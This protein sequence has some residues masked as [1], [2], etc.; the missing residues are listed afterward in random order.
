MAPKLK[1]YFKTY[2]RQKQLQS[3]QRNC[4]KEIVKEQ[5]MGAQAYNPSP[6]RL[7]QDSEF[8]GPE[9]KSQILSQKKKK[10]SNRSNNSSVAASAGC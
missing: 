7:G 5:H 10:K 6:Q 8:E 9:L 2:M 4:L 1:Q 3:R